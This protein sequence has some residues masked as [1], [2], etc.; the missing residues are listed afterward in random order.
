MFRCSNCGFENP[1]NVLHCTQCN[2]RLDKEHEAI[3]D[4]SPSDTPS[5]N[6]N[7]TRRGLAA[8]TPFLDE[9][10]PV[11]NNPASNQKTIEECQRCSYPLSG[12]STTCPSCGY[13]N[14]KKGNLS[15]VIES[16]KSKP[17]IFPQEDDPIPIEKPEPPPLTKGKNKTINLSQLG[18]DT[19]APTLKFAL[20]SI[21]GKKSIDFEL[22]EE[23]QLVFNR[24]SLDKN[25]PTIS[26][27][28]HF[29]I[30]H[31]NGEWSIEDLSSNQA[32]FIQVDKKMPI[33]DNAVIIVG[34][35]IFRF[36]IKSE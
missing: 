21:D 5:G 2:S 17:G 23:G 8:Q 16:P 30:S 10:S 28:E 31:D 34:N 25:N 6:G 7:K 29:Q 13:D 9:P 1:A 22:D 27:K 18:F 14:A 19:G 3:P 26:S 33:K 20:E 4:S 36:K 24:A 12:E 15:Q 32:T 35:K 11:S